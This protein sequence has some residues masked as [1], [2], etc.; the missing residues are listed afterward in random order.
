MTRRNSKGRDGE[1]YPLIGGKQGLCVKRDPLFISA[2]KITAWWL[3]HNSITTYKDMATYL[4]VTDLNKTRL[5]RDI[6]AGFYFGC[7]VADT[8]L[9]KMAESI[10][11]AT[12]GFTN[13]MQNQE[14]E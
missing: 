14:E 7:D 12:L 5:M 1:I 9:F 11:S 4:A 13:G 10:V 6:K 3:E 8:P 2:D